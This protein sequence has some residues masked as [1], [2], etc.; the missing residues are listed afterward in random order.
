YSSEQHCIDGFKHAFA[1]NGLA[2]DQHWISYT[3]LSKEDAFRSAI[4]MLQ[5]HNLQ[6]IITSSE[7]ISKGLI[8]AAHVRG[9][10]IPGNLLVL[11]LGQDRWNL[12][13]SSQG[14]IN[15]L[16]PALN[17]GEE[18]ARLLIKNM[19][20]PILFEK[21][22]I[23]LEDKVVYKDIELK[24]RTTKSEI[25]LVKK[26]T[27]NVLMLESPTAVSIEG[28][29]PHF[30]NNTFIDVNIKTY[31]QQYILDKIISDARSKSQDIDV[32]MF[33]IP[34]L[35]FIASNKY[36]MNLTKFINAHDFD[37]NI[38]IPGTLKHFSE[39]EGEYYGVPFM[40]AP[41]ILFYRKDLFEDKSL[42]REFEARYKTELTPPDTWL[43]FNAIAE[44]FTKSLNPSSPVEYGTSVAANYSE[45]LVPEFLPRLWSYNGRIFNEQN[46]VTFNSPETI[47][48]MTNFCKTFEFTRPDTLNQRIEDTVADFYEGKTAM[49]ICYISYTTDIT[50]RFKSDIVGKIGYDFIP[51]KTPVLGGWS[52]GIN[53]NSKNPKQAFKF[54]NW[55]CGTDICNYHTILEG[56]SPLMDVY[57]NDELDKLYPWLPL[58]LETFKYCR[59]RKGP[60]IQGGKIIPQDNIEFIIAKAIY[61]VLKKETTIENALNTAQQALEQLFEDYGYPQK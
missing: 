31:P 43:E 38:F 46:K 51:G 45:L 35:P 5:N 33:D 17:M 47:K 16:R 49:L 4:F 44:F 6:G 7:T 23:V 22:R 48:A 14:V 42:K 61:S 32:Y 11:S 41:Q 52:M 57:N 18:A 24:N 2:L 9:I 55:A 34:W 56:Q 20:S 28:L 26:G 25:T 54:I 21:Q 27:L 36:L 53:P 3:N 29:L 8:E 1:R 39:F 37:K 19:Q 59:T 40:Y 12:Y 15:T 30:T 58:G 10:D 60:H 13:S 50:N